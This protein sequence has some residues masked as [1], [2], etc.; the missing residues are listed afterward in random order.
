MARC[1]A[2]AFVTD[3][4]VRDIRASAASASLFLHWRHAQFTRQG[5]SCTWAFDRRRRRNRRPGDIVVGDQT[6]S[7]SYRT[8]VDSITDKLP[9][10][11]AAEAELDASVKAG[12]KIRRSS[13]PSRSL[14]AA[15]KPT[16]VNR[17]QGG[18]GSPVPHCGREDLAEDL[19]CL[20]VFA[21]F[22]AWGCGAMNVS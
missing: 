9:Q 2:V 4:C 18:R 15:A 12:M 11:R 13:A 16:P 7:W 14:R 5:R 17:R 1:G 19:V 10:V 21:P 8:S 3:G 22:W 6:A 20:G